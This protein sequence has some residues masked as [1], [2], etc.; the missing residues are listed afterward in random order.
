MDEPAQLLD[1]GWKAVATG[2]GAAARTHA[3]EVL[4]Q[5]P[6]DPEAL[7]LL[8]AALR[9]EGDLAE[10]LAVFESAHAKDG[11]YPEPALSAAELHL[12][13]TGDFEAALRL[14]LK[15]LS[16]EE[17]GEEDRGAAHLLRAEAWLGLGA[18][19]SG[20]EELDGI[21]PAARRSV[22]ALYVR[23]RALYELER[24][25]EA[26]DTLGQVVE[27]KE[28][29]ADAH[30]ALALIHQGRGEYEEMVWEFQRVREIETGYPPA[31]HALSRDAFAAL[32]ETA[33]A[34]LP[35][36]IRERLG[37]VAVLI[38]D[39]PSTDLVEEGIDP[40]LL[41]IFDGLPYPDKTS[42]VPRGPDQI[43][44]YQANLEAF[45]R[46]AE[47][48]VEEIVKTVR[49]ESGHYFGLDEEDLFQRDLD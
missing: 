39:R 43:V 27:L 4:R 15:V 20:L 10:A 49:H 11:T 30:Y 5:F 18:A 46:S 8:G 32:A 29:H 7:T 38:E 9:L 25:E 17:A 22:D 24:D 12:D 14:G 19:E 21:P 31:P 35:E 48:I 13:L 34:E 2:D 6:Q 45:C 37:E 44:L 26:F 42:G 41:G 47:E 28:D 3:R 33:L 40:R 16:M 23:G 1:R 36:E